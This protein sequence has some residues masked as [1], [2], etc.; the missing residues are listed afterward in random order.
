MPHDV[1]ATKQQ[2]EDLKKQLRKLHD[3]PVNTDGVQDAMLLPITNYLLDLKPGKDGVLHWF[4]KDADDVG[5]EAALFLLRL[6]AY[7]NDL[8][9]AWKTQMLKCL[10]GCAVCIQSLDEA[11]VSVRTTCVRSAFTYYSVAHCRVAR[12]YFGSFLSDVMNKFWIVFEEWE[13]E[14]LV[15][16]IKNAGISQQS[17]RSFK[18]LPPPIFYHLLS[19]AAAFK[20]TF[21][22]DILAIHA[23]P[24]QVTNVPTRPLPPG[25]LLLL[26]H[27]SAVIRSWVG[28][29]FD[30]GEEIKAVE[31]HGLVA[32]AI[33]ERIA[34]G[35]SSS[36]KA[37]PAV[38][39]ANAFPFISSQE[40]FWNELETVIQILP[41]VTVHSSGISKAL[42]G[43][44][45]GTNS[46]R[47]L[48][49]PCCVI[50][51]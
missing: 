33:S 24:A 3:E 2:R 20:D 27:E 37:D 35:S 42:I 14:E 45:H 12:R 32:R 50:S 43:H 31:Q 15:K 30:V 22:L 10:H 28:T 34:R 13:V 36:K 47:R 8:V 16:A 41:P 5:R 39:I 18:N 9:T 7:K 4:C 23:L 11:K 44:L 29:H 51:T 17:S 6:F 49:L 38:A 40:Q 25:C 21:V 46:S 48:P 1:G 26:L 19:K